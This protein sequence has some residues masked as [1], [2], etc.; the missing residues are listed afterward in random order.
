MG[1]LK[2]LEVTADIYRPLQGSAE[3]LVVTGGWRH[4]LISN[5]RP[6]L[7]E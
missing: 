6:G 3:G 7:H 1:R 4:R 5:G 2:F